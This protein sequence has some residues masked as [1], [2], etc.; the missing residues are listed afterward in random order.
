MKRKVS[1]VLSTALII[2]GVIHTVFTPIFY[3]QF[4]LDAVWFAG[5]GI[6]FIFLGSYNLTRR[7]DVSRLSALLATICNFLALLWLIAFLYLEGTLAP[8]GLIS[9]LILGM[10]VVLTTKEVFYK[11]S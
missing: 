1:G 5:S 2:L 11:A 6:G 7:S 4:N 8:Q 10:M 3:P 9:L